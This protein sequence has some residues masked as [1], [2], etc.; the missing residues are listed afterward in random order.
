MSSLLPSS[1]LPRSEFQTPAA[2]LEW[3]DG[4]HRRR[5]A[6]VQ[7]LRTAIAKGDNSARQEWKLR[8]A[9]GLGRKASEPWTGPSP[10]RLGELKVHF[11]RCVH[12]TKNPVVE[13]ADACAKVALD[14]MGP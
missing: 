12:F 7:E 3:M 4:F 8:S 1:G 10:A 2:Y 11:D 6:R 9:A 14:G 13:L 5:L